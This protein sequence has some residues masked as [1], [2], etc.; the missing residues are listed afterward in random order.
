M[1]KT[2]RLRVIAYNSSVLRLWLRRSIGRVVG[3]R[4]FRN[5]FD[6]SRWLLPS[7]TLPGRF[8]LERTSCYR[9]IINLGY[10]F[11]RFLHAGIAGIALYEIFE[12][13]FGL[14]G[15]VQIVAIN[16]ADGEQRLCPVF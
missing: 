13:G 10:S 7:G 5:F 9:W 8:G 11:A 16:F 1:R 12:R 15:V 6:C 2:M 3:N 14:L 4:G